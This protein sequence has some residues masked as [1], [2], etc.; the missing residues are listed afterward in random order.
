MSAEGK[1]TLALLALAC[2]A[3]LDFG[4]TGGPDEPTVEVTGPRLLDT[5]CAQGAYELEGDAVR[6]GG[7]TPD[8]CGFELGPGDGSIT[9][10]TAVSANGKSLGD[11]GSDAELRA[12]V[13]N[14][15]GG[16]HD[17]QWVPLTVTDQA[18]SL[19]SGGRH[20][21]LVDVEAK[22]TIPPYSDS[23]GCSV[24]HRRRNP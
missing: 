17:P 18:A 4:T 23:G 7:L 11:L 20:L 3:C 15:D 9:F 21:A 2:G 16:A 24:A 14:L 22:V 13:V 8:A 19:S 1:R 12:L 10:S 5:L 6:A